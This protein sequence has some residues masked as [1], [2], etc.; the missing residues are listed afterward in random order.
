MPG[1]YYQVDEEPSQWIE[2]D[3]DEID[4]INEDLAMEEGY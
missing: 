2:I 3:Q 4:Q 1:T